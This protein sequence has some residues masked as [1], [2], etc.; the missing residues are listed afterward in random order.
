M[1]TAVLQRRRKKAHPLFSVGA[2]QVSNLSLLVSLKIRKNNLTS[3]P[4]EVFLLETMTLLDLTG[5]AIRELPDEQ[6]G[7][8][9][10]LKS[11]LLSGDVRISRCV[12]NFFLSFCVSVFSVPFTG[13]YHDDLWLGTHLASWFSR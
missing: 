1:F 13:N 2:H 9:V 10:V 7:A 8:A 4:A 11:L 5:N 6:L 12:N 3:V